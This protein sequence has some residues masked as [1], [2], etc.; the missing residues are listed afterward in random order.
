MGADLFALLER[1]WRTLRAAPAAYTLGVV[2]AAGGFVMIGIS[3]GSSLEIVTVTT[4]VGEAPPGTSESAVDLRLTPIIQVTLTVDRCGPQF[5]LL[6]D[7]QY[8]DWMLFG[9][10]PPPTLTCTQLESLLT[11]R[12]GY[13]VTVYL[14]SPGAPGVPYS[15]IVAFWGERHPYA[16]LS[17]PGAALS[18]GATVWI[19]L[20]MFARGTEKLLRTRPLSRREK[21]K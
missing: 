7:V 1:I 18:L 21:R 10:L 4:V 11:E 16:L 20:T 15:I 13:L 12:I 2:L 14:T 9:R 5:F 8:E 17:I 6:T 19:A 3:L